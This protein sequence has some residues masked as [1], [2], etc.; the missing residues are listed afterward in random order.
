MCYVSQLH[1]AI[2]RQHIIK[3]S[4]ALRTLSI[5]LFNI[6]RTGRIIL[7]FLLLNV[8]DQLHNIMILGYVMMQHIPCSGATGMHNWCLID[9]HR[10]PE[11]LLM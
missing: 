3:E 6:L 9:L 7:R 4:T 8:A 11:Y 1:G 5:V 2:F 10:P